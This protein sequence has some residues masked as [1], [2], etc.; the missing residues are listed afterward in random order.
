MTEAELQ[1]RYLPKELGWLAFNARVLQEAQDETV[2]LIERIRFL[3]I[4]SSNLDEFFRVRVA[5]LHRLAEMGARA[6]K[7]IHHDPQQVLNQVM[8]R[9]KQL[10]AI[11]NRTYDQLIAELAARDISIVNESQLT[12]SQRSWLIDYFN[13]EIRAELSPLLLKRNDPMPELQDGDIYLAVRMSDSVGKRKQR[14]ALIEL[15]H[16]LERFVVLPGGGRETTL[17][18]VDDIVRM[19]LPSVFA[20]FKHDQL[21][22]WTIKLTR[23]AELDLDDDLTKS[24]SAKLAASI[25]QR[26]HGQPVRFVYDEALPEDLL[27]FFSKKLKLGGQDTL[28]PGGRYHNRSDLIRFPLVGPRS[29]RYGPAPVIRHKAIPETDSILSEVRKSDRLLHFPYNPFSQ[30]VDLMREAALDPKVSRIQTTLYRLARNSDIIRSLITARRNG[31]QVTA[32]VEL[33]ARFDEEANIHWAERLREEGIEVIIGVQGLKVHSKLALIERYHGKSLQQVACVGTGNFN[34]DTAQVFEDLLMMTAD[35]RIT[36]EVEQIFRFFE[37]TY[38]QLKFEHMLVSPWNTRSPIEAVIRHEIAEAREGRP[39]LIQIKNNNLADY[40]II[41]LLYEA[42]EAG[43]ELRLNVRGMFSMRPESR[44]STKAMAMI[45][46]FLEHSRLMHF[47]HGGQDLVYM[48]SGDLLPRNLDRRVEA[49][50]PVYD[51]G[52]RSYLLEVLDLYWLDDRKAR[53]LDHELSNSYRGRDGQRGRR[54]AQKMIALLNQKLHG[55]AP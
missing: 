46:R 16:S 29:L 36:R 52:I 51:E 12:E 45:D 28:L 9:V 10:H 26:E 5:T 25:K 14:L 21:E 27:N 37:K 50:C 23:D 48:G 49:F 8:K 38:L 6:R 4:Y 53:V 15:P 30:F 47:H 42:E 20:L 18:I 55:E 44:Q 7:L 35:P 31:K 39:A 1:K 41:D 13:R 34:E 19:M 40:P 11:Y 2:P 17:I 24:F 33:Q 43:V 54:R 32:V 22:A 3:G